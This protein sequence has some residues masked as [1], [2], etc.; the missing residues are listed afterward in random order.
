MNMPNL[1]VAVLMLLA[2]LGFFWLTH[3]LQR[4]FQWVSWT[5]YFALPIVL[6][7]W[8]L[9]QGV[10]SPFLWVKLYS[11]IAFSG[12]VTITR[13]TKLKDS[14]WIFA[15]FYAMI[16]LNIFVGVVGPITT[17]TYTSYINGATGLLLIATLPGPQRVRVDTNSPHQDLLYDL[18][19]TWL[20]LYTLWDLLFTYMLSPVSLVLNI[21]CLT[22]PWLII[23]TNRNRQLWT[24]ARALT[25]SNFMMVP[26]T[27]PGILQV[28]HVP[29]IDQQ[30][31][32][33]S[34][35]IGLIWIAVHAVSVAR[36][37]LGMHNR[38]PSESHI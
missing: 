6:L 25:I 26:F 29:Q 11:L 34:S 23:L 9:Q 17:R 1:V 22:V 7:P 27:F 36:S 33:V 31:L 38:L 21:P 10:N 35:T 20:A 14:R 24:Q 5:W 37:R 15:L 8:W 4:R 30:V 12:I 32:L 3:D 2:Y 19:L 16:V 28:V 13:F 18:P